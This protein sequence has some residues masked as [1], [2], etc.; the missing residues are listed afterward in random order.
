MFVVEKA[1]EACA[2]ALEIC[3]RMT[4][5]D[6][7]PVRIGAD[8]GPVLGRSGD[9]FGEVVNRAARLV[10]LAR[11]GTVVVTDSVVAAVGDGWAVEQLPPQ[12]LKGFQAPAVSYRLVV[13]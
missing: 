9:Y 3:E 8:V 7:P 4:E 2:A 1:D 6:L 13:R 10:A 11:P 5:A 12:A